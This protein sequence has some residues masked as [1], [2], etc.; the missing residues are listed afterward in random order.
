MT[1]TDAGDGSGPLS[2]L[3][4]AY[5]TEGGGEAWTLYFLIV[6]AALFVV[7]VIALAWALRVDAKASPVALLLIGLAGL[8]G[9]ALAYGLGLSLSVTLADRGVEAVASYTVA[10][11]L[12]SMVETALGWIVA[13]AVLVV[14]FVRALRRADPGERESPARSTG[15]PT[16]ARRHGERL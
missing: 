5:R 7:E 10:T 15:A 9:R 11:H 16:P 6:T 1:A 8:V 13:A 2:P 12:D 14:L 4:R 3:L